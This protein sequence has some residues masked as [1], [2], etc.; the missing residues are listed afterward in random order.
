MKRRTFLKNAT[1]A[2]LAPAG[3]TQIAQAA[4]GRRIAFG[5][6]QIECSTYGHNRTRLGDFRVRR[7]QALADDPFFGPLKTY[8]WPFQP[9]LLAQAVPGDPVERGTYD[10]LKAE[11]LQRL[12]AMLPLDG[13]YLAMHGAMYV[14]GMEDAEGDWISATREV[15]GGD[16]LVTASF[17]L[18]GNLSRRIID[19]LDMLSAFRTAPHIDREETMRRACDML[20]RC[21]NEHIRPTVVWAPIPVLLPGERTSTVYEP[22]KRLWGQLPAMNAG[23]GVMDASLMVGYVWADE[24]RATA[25]AILTGTNRR[26]LER[27]ALS[28]AQQYWDARREFKFGV[29]TGTLAECIDRAK[30]LATK[31]VV[32]SDSGDNP[33]GG[34]TGD[35]AEIVAALLQH[36]VQNA[37]IA[38]IADRPATEACYKARVG[39]SLQLRIGGTIDP[40]GSQPVQI[41]AKV[42]SL[43][44]TDNPPE[45]QA[46][47][48]VDGVTVV[49]TARRRPF[50]EIKDFTVLGLDPTRLKILVVKAGYLV[51]EIAAIANPNLMALTDGAVNQDIEHLASKHRVPTWPFQPDLKWKPSTVV[52]ARSP[53]A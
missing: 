19:N 21:L 29:P 32:I 36:K 7:G 45:R 25:S 6:I 34:G 40:R 13:V 8:P 4:D 35:R 3:A 20:I 14:D 46:V 1:A 31:P 38:G 2:A 42:V 33:T 26:I 23:P 28:L 11:F 51:P 47:V 9:T 50:H 52:S 49:L 41:A 53:A 44:A 16:C 24:R 18:H 48:E 27:D 22:A 37:L 12:K 39:A 30:G 17:D 10:E 5:G 15:V 43:L